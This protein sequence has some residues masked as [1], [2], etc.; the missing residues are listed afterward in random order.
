MFRRIGWRCGMV[1]L[2]TVTSIACSNS[3]EEQQGTLPGPQA[4]SGGDNRSLAAYTAGVVADS[5]GNDSD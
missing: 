2:Y 1:A 4:G 3:G 5:L